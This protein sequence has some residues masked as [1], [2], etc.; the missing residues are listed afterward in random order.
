MV[1][2]LAGKGAQARYAPTTTQDRTSYPHVLTRVEWNQSRN[3]DYNSI[4]PTH[5]VTRYGMER[6]EIGVWELGC[7]GAVRCVL[8]DLTSP[9]PCPSNACNTTQHSI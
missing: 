4:D 1:H 3:R 9:S 7:C 6:G 2:G 8:R 5:G